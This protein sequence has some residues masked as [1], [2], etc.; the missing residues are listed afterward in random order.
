MEP[1]WG[2][3]GPEGLAGKQG[4]TTSFL[5]LLTRR[6]WPLHQEQELENLCPQVTGPLTASAVSNP[7]ALPGPGY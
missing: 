5:T 2:G 4:C 7:P 3:V 1:R 6:P